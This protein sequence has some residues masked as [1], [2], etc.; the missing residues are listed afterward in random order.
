EVDRDATARGRELGMSATQWRLTFSPLVKG[1]AFIQRLS[2]LLKTLEAAYSHPVDVE[3][4]LH[5]DQDG[6]P[7]FNLV[8][9][10]P[11]ATIGETGQV[12]LPDNVA[13][14]HLLFR[15][16]GNFM[17]GNINLTIDRVIRVDAATYASLA[18][19]EKHQVA[20]Q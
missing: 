3:F 14:E 9:C 18:I 11:L 19:A 10:R 8:Q 17:G 12:T 1:T 2:R 6:E 5:L 20:S 4:T 16:E 13:D 15:S 7:A